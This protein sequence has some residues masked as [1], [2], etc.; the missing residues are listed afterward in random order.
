MGSRLKG[1]RTRQSSLRE[2]RALFK[3]LIYGILGLGVIALL[4]Y[5]WL[6]DRGLKIVEDMKR[7]APEGRQT[8]TP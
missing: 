1:K 5:L 6:S 7:D 8:G 2:R 3:M 4:W